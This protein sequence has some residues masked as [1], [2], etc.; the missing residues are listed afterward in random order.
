MFAVT[1]GFIEV[2]R[3]LR[4]RRRAVAVVVSA[5]M[6]GACTDSG[7][8]SAPAVHLETTQVTE[9][10][11][12][13]LTPDGRFILPSSAVNPVGEISEVQARALASRYVSDVAQFRVAEWSASYGS[14]IEPTA[15]I[16]CDHALHAATPYASVTGG[17]LSPLT[18][19]TFG[20]HWI[21]PMCGRNGALQMVVSFAALAT[22]LTPNLGTKQVIPW[23]EA[24]AL[25]FGVPAG[26]ASDMYSP[27][28][29]TAYA[30][31]KGGK[32][33]ASIPE[34]VMNPMPKAPALV[35]WQIDLET[36]IN[37]I[38]TE[39]GLT[40]QRGKLLVGF[41]DTFRSSGLLDANPKAAAPVTSWVDAVTHQPFTV[42]LGANTP[43]GVE[44]VTGGKP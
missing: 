33:I 20:P 17:K 21:V 36:P 29:A 8:V 28:G 30:F 14:P 23:S 39:S 9:A 43:Q 6:I 12:A 1:E 10:V 37:V 41:G 5:L 7:T 40:R 38:G 13:S 18:L 16:P 22:E 19:H 15:L 2:V 25:S 11:A 42:V 27:E 3:A 32:R 24:D 44:I 4:A 26:S 31:K 34:L 35:R